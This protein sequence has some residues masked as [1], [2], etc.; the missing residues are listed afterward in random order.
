MLTRGK[1]TFHYSS[2][3]SCRCIGFTL[4][5]VSVHQ[6]Y[7]KQEVSSA[8]FNLGYQSTSVFRFTALTVQRVGED[9]G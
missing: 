4:M 6:T 1:V 2:L 7:N 8:F 9:S 3:G 5:L